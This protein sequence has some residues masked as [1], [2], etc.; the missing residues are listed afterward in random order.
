MKKLL[1]IFIV[2]VLATGALASCGVDGTKTPPAPASPDFSKIYFDAKHALRGEHLEGSPKDEDEF[3]SFLRLYFIYVVGNNRQ[4][5]VHKDKSYLELVDDVFKLEVYWA[6][7]KAE[8]LT[9]E[10]LS[11]LNGESI[12]KGKDTDVKEYTHYIIWISWKNFDA[13]AILKLSANENVEMIRFLELG[14]IEIDE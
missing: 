12:Y 14:F 9:E 5:P 11:G 10:D 3:K 13:D 8:N 6:P 4:R 7:G 2:I 1:A